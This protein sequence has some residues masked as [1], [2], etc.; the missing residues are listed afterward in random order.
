M[1]NSTYQCSSTISIDEFVNADMV[2]N[3]RIVISISDGANTA[4]ADFSIYNR[5]P[6]IVIP[7]IIQIA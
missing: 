2:L 1:V 3:Q 5:Q 7:H 4:E 6:F